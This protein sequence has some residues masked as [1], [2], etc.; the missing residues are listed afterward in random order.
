MKDGD[1]VNLEFTGRIKDTNEI[2]DTTSEESA[3]QAGIFNEKTSYGP[4]VIIIGANQ[5]IPGLE[6]ALKEMNVGEK[7]K[8]EVPPEKGFGMKNPDM[9]KLLPM[10]VFKDNNMDPAPGRIVNFQDFQGK[11]LSVDGGRVKVDFNH[12]IAGKIVEYE[13]EIKDQISD[14]GRQM[15]SVV[16]YFTGV[17]YGDF[18]TALNG[19]EATVTIPKFD[20]PRQIK[21]TI[22]DTI[23]KWISGISKVS[24]IDAFEKKN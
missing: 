2:F 4:I 5:V 1:F 6:D 10:S 8:V 3:K 18:T 11:I 22:A 12:P 7:K 15:N 20:F 14:I 21:Q 17:K 23:M 9:I 13:V 16:R 19:N 24:F